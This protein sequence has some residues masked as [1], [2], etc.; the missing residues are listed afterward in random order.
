MT[1]RVPLYVKLMVSYLLVVGLVLL[2]TAVYLRTSLI[3]DQHARAHAALRRELEGITP[4]LADA[5]SGQLE[6]R[7][8]LLLVTLPTRLTVVD[9]AGDVLGDSLRRA[10]KLENHAGRPEV[11]EALARGVGYSIRVSATTR[12]RTV[13]TAMR[14]PREGPARGVARLSV[15]EREVVAAGAQ[16]EGMVRNTAAV[17]LSAA[18][19]LSLVAALVVSRPLRR[20]ASGARAFADGDF[21]AEIDVR[22]N[23]EIGEVAEALAALASQLRARLVATGAERATLQAVLDDLPVGVVLFDAERRPVA[24]NGAAR[25]LCG[26]EPFAENARGAELPRLERQPAAVESVLR[27]GFTVETNLTLPWRPGATLAARWFVHFGP[28]GDRRLGLVVID[29]EATARV[30]A[31]HDALAR[32]VASQRRCLGDLRDRALAAELVTLL[33]QTDALLAPPAVNAENVSAQ[34]V[35]DLC[36]AAAGDLAPWCESVGARFEFALP[37]GDPRVVDVDDR[38][39][40]ALR[41]LLRWAAGDG[42]SVVVRVTPKDGGW[43]FSMRGPSLADDALDAVADLVRPVGGD[44]GSDA[45]DDHTERWIT[46]P[47]A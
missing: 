37:E 11:R 41:A 6:A 31:L 47:R 29:R 22:L 45:R 15:P 2:P 19:L 23:D 7:V 4:R 8:E 3:R 30:E 12:E 20:I 35:E 43:R 36:R 38:V 24:L 21:G 44:A 33:H 17:A 42:G 46:A 18:V 39:R 10:E 9:A 25:A 40:R 27:D 14:F 13:Y 1:V 5:P 34:R 32:V 26:L 28:E 16:I